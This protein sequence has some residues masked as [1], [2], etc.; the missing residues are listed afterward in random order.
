[1]SSSAQIRTNRRSGGASKPLG[2]GGRKGKSIPSFSFT[3]PVE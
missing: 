1:M 2:G 3:W